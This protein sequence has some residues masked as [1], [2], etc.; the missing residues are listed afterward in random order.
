MVRDKIGSNMEVH[1]V[2]RWL[3]DWI[4]NYICGDPSTASESILAERPL[5]AAAVVVEADESDPGY[6]KATFRLRPHFQ[7]ERMDISLRLVSR[8]RNKQT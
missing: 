1:D 7:L 4:Q 6:Y 3:N 8:V 5:S 2:E